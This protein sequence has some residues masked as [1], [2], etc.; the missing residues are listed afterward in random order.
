MN[1]QQRRRN[2]KIVFLISI[3]LVIAGV[4][5]KWILGPIAIHAV[6]YKNMEITEGTM[7]YDTWVGTT[8]SSKWHFWETEKNNHPIIVIYYYFQ[9][10]PP[11]NLVFSKYYIW[12][13]ENPDEIK[14]GKKPRVTQFGPYVYREHRI[15]EDIARIGYDK[16]SSNSST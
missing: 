16:I 6:V 1:I 3:V 5:A 4:L 8:R 14:A 11:Q 10:E 7:A 13:V 12:N 15:K 9:Y 2:F